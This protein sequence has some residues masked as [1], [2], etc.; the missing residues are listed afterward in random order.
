MAQNAF[1]VKDGIV[2]VYKHNC[3][4]L[5]IKLCGHGQVVYGLK[6]FVLLLN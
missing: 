2:I 6:Y 3:G 1:I 4:R 5:I